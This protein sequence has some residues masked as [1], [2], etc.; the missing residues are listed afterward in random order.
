MTK[1]KFNAGAVIDKP[2]NAVENK[3]GSWRTFRPMVDHSKC[4]KCGICEWYCPD[5]AIRLQEI[6]GEKKIVIDYNHCKGCLICVE[7]CPHGA[8]RKER[9]E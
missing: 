2:G 9:E 6:K 1:E 4:K 3:T 5:R 7:M 8:L